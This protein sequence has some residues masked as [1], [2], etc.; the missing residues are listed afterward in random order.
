MRHFGGS[1]G[2]RRLV[3]PDFASNTVDTSRLLLF[4]V[5]A[6]ELPQE[7]PV[8]PSNN[9]A[10]KRTKPAKEAVDAEQGPAA[11]PTSTKS[12]TLEKS[13]VLPSA[14]VQL[15]RGPSGMT[16]EVIHLRPSDGFEFPSVCQDGSHGERAPQQEGLAQGFREDLGQ[17]FGQDFRGSLDISADSGPRRPQNMTMQR[18][19]RSVSGIGCEEMS[20]VNGGILAE[21]GGG[22]K[23]IVG[24][25]AGSPAHAVLAAKD[26][27]RLDLQS[28][29]GVRVTVRRRMARTESRVEREERRRKLDF[30]RWERQRKCRLRRAGLE[31][32]K[33]RVRRYNRMH[34]VMVRG[35]GLSGQGQKKRRVGANRVRHSMCTTTFQKIVRALPLASSRK[36]FFSDCLL[37]PLSPPS[38][39]LFP[40]P[41][42]RPGFCQAFGLTGGDLFS[43]V[44]LSPVLRLVHYRFCASD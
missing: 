16:K 36:T 34:G 18:V 1:P 21:A 24:G 17:G 26:L 20:P 10:E 37:S 13:E 11:N 12:L 30:S 28:A 39:S 14:P 38:M 27:V 31:E 19:P 41:L 25:S 5:Q 42:L 43:C 3:S 8:Y 23:G 9:A 15:P 2:A 40:R 6:D 35:N 32:A 29:H 44:S 33:T 22:G 4:Y 7:S